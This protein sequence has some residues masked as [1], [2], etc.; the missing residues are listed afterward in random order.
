MHFI[1]NQTVQGPKTVSVQT[2][3]CSKG[4]KRFQTINE[5]LIKWNDRSFKKK[6]K[7]L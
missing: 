1:G 4:F 5:G 2:E 3:N 6:K 7:S